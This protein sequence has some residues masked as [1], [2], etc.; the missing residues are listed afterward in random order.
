M[1]KYITNVTENLVDTFLKV[2]DE[3]NFGVIAQPEFDEPLIKYIQTRYKLSNFECNQL[4]QIVREHEKKPTYTILVDPNLTT[5]QKQALK[6]A[7]K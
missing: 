2:G 5:K 3:M 7:T 6:N 1:E 4:I